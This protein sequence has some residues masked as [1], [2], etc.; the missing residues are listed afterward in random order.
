[1]KMFHVSKGTSGM[2]DY[3]NHKGLEV[4]VMVPKTNG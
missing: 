2:I 4:Y 3:A 1:M